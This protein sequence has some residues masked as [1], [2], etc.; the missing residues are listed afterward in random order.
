MASPRRIPLIASPLVNF[1]I[2]SEK[3]NEIVLNWVEWESLEMCFHW[4]Q[5]IFSRHGLNHSKENFHEQ[6]N[7]ISSHLARKKVHS[8]NNN[9]T[10]FFVCAFHKGLLTIIFHNTP[11]KKNA[12]LCYAVLVFEVVAAVVGWMIGKFL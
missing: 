3:L 8:N 1:F 9:K 11:T 6:V 4:I 10:F 5:F 12:V 7:F 2:S